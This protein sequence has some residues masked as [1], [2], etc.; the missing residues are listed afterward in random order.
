MPDIITRACT[1]IKNAKRIY[2]DGD[3]LAR[4]GFVKGARYTKFITGDSYILKL[5]VNGKFIVSGKKKRNLEIYDPVID[6]CN[7][8]FSGFTGDAEQVLAKL[9][10]NIICISI[11]ANE[12]RKAKREADFEQA[13]RAKALT[14]GTLCVGIGMS[15]LALH[16]GFADAGY[17]LKTK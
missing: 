15:T 5:D 2:L 16:D 8:E 4:N 3:V 1:A 17:S 14:E 9:E 12:K 13:S 11:H 10:Q 7:K 6:I